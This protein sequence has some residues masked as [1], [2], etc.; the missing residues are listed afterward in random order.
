MTP[1]TLNSGLLLQTLGVTVDEQS[2]AT[3]VLRVTLAGLS[4]SEPLTGR[5]ELP[6]EA[7]ENLEQFI[8]GDGEPS[9]TLLQALHEKSEDLKALIAGWPISATLRMPTEAVLPPSS[10]FPPLPEVPRNPG[11]KMPMP[12]D[13]FGLVL[14][15][16]DKTLFGGDSHLRMVF[17]ALKTRFAEL[18]GLENPIRR[19]FETG[20][21]TWRYRRHTLDPSS[22]AGAVATLLDEVPVLQVARDWADAGARAGLKRGVLRLVHEQAREVVRSE[23]Q[24]L[25]EEGRM[26]E[27]LSDQEL[28]EEARTRIFIVSSQFELVLR[29][30]TNVG[31][32]HENLLGLNPENILGSQGTF[33]EKGHFVADDKF[34]Y[35]FD[36]NKP[37]MVEREIKKRGIECNWE[38]TRAFTDDVWYDR[39][40]L[41]LA[42][43]PEH[44]FIIDPDR[45]DSNYAR[46]EGTEVVY[47]QWDLGYRARWVANLKSARKKKR[48]EVLQEERFYPDS[49]S[50]AS[51]GDA[52]G[53]ALWGATEMAPVAAMEGLLHGLYGVGL[54]PAAIA[55]PFGAGMLYGP[56]NRSTRSDLIVG[57]VLAAGMAVVHSAASPMM[58]VAAA[59]VGGSLLALGQGLVKLLVHERSAEE[60][61]HRGFKTQTR[62]MSFLWRTGVSGAWFALLRFLGMA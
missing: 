24:S 48:L 32:E 43:K 14:T 25:L 15:D 60:L 39:F 13:G 18:R 5:L 38:T 29:M 47:D 61:G 50:V 53:R 40:L 28:E 52:W 12:K 8:G 16:F 56:L 59:V 54:H 30:L 11:L 34:E 9:E 21:M 36:E 6:T 49:R 10:L 7:R 35:C 23:V 17:L 42:D 46:H 3:N 37:R 62:V 26:S 2:V 33:A 45:R 51:I 31:P 58:P 55:V 57:T 41:S 4:A 44:R 1:P 22:A 27:P 19:L 20:K